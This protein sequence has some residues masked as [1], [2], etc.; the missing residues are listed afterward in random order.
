ML[1][2]QVGSQLREAGR[3]SSSGQLPGQEPSSSSPRLWFTAWLSFFLFQKG[4]ENY[5]VPE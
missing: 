3:K 2:W 4:S 5:K 1:A